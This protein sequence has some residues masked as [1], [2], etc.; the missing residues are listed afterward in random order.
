[1]KIYEL[2]KEAIVHKKQ[3]HAEYKGYKREMCPHV[4]GTKN[5]VP[6]ALFYQ[7]G[8]SSSKGLKND[9]SN[10]RCIKIDELENVSIKEGK[11]HTGEVKTNR[12]N[13]CVDIIDVE[14]EQ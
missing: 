4:L 9:L 5:N 7:F 1:M 14:V 12:G 2:I 11:W 13:T 8:G 3:I 6:Q 10:W